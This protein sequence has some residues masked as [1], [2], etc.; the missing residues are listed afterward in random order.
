MY[1]LQGIFAGM[2]YYRL[3]ELRAPKSSYVY[4]MVDPAAAPAG[5]SSVPPPAYTLNPPSYVAEASSSPLFE[6]PPAKEAAGTGT[7]AKSVRGYS[8]RVV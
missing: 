7:K 8:N 5:S 1:I 4:E 2:A 6:L 3:Q